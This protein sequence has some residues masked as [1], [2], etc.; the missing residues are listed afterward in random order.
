LSKKRKAKWVKE[1]ANFFLDLGILA[2]GTF[3]VRERGG[4]QE[5]LTYA[6]SGVAFVNHLLW[7]CNHV[8]AHV[9]NIILGLYLFTNH[10]SISFIIAC[11]HKVT[12]TTTALR[13]SIV[14]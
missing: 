1:K 8:H 12:T 3:Y 10:C 9:Q 7:D 14:I 11:M 13:H 5:V 6:S 2:S 4:D